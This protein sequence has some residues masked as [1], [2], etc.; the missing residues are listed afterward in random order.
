MKLHDEQK[1]EIKGLIESLIGDFTINDALILIAVCA[2]KEQAAPGDEPIDEA[3]RIADLAQ[4]HPIFAGINDSIEPSINKFMNLISTTT[5]LVKPVDMAANLLEPQFKK[6]AFGWA[7]EIT[8][9]D[10]VLTEERKS[11][12]DKYALVLNVDRNDAQKIIVDVSK[13][14]KQKR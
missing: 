8:M 4:N 14:G 3:N 10:G 1:G 13:I 7:A 5:D 6:G 12:L 11:I 2:A 9:P